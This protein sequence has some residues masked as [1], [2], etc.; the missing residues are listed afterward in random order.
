MNLNDVNISH[1]DLLKYY[2]KHLD[3]FVSQFQDCDT[4]ILRNVSDS[5][6]HVDRKKHDINQ[7]TNAVN[8][9]LRQITTHFESLRIYQFDDMSENALNQDLSELQIKAQMICSK[10]EQLQNKAD[11]ISSKLY[12]LEN[13]AKMHSQKISSDIK[14]A[15][16]SINKYVNN[17]E[18]YKYDK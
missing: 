9:A 4:Q 17:I 11:L 10:L 3:E 16:D 15:K 5:E 13:K 12:S 8:D 7:A 2:C 1:S 18:E 14:M 6:L